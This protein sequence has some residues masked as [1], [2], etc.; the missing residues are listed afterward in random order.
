MGKSTNNYRIIDL[1]QGLGVSVIVLK[2]VGAT[3]VWA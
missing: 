1:F 3:T 2:R